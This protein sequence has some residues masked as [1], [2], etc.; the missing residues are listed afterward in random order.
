L[1]ATKAKISDAQARV[2]SLR[3]DEARNMQAIRHDQRERADAA[4]KVS[5]EQNTL[6]AATRLVDAARAE[7]QAEIKHRAAS[8]EDQGKGIATERPAGVL[9]AESKALNRQSNT[10]L[11]QSHSTQA[12]ALA[13]LDL[14]MAQGLADKASDG[15]TAAKKLF[16]RA[17]AERKDAVAAAAASA[18]DII[19]AA[20]K[21]E[22]E[23][24]DDASLRHVREGD[25]V[26]TA[27]E[28]AVIEADARAV[29]SAEKG[30][31][32]A[33]E[34][35]QTAQGD[36]ARLASHLATVQDQVDP[37]PPTLRTNR[38]RRILHPVLIGHAACFTPY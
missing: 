26:G 21:S 36:R 10:V 13:A 2:E 1:Q 6:R 28:Q 35:L 20:Y 23:N 11:H 19:H 24:R 9:L 32:Q 14:K 3:S 34:A 22:A 27:A 25:T 4:L 38:T 12:K 37:P 18:K 15:M 7:Q 33:K 31:G 29:D 17:I 8:E 5:E 30:L 16:A